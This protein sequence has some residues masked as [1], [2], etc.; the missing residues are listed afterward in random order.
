MYTAIIILNYNNAN[1]TINCVES[2]MKFNTAN[3]KLIVVDNGSSKG[4]TVLVL[5]EYFSKKFI[6]NYLRVQDE[7]IST[8]SLPLLTFDVSGE[9]SGYARGNNKGLSL[10]YRDSEI[11]YIMILNNDTLF[12]DD[13]IPKLLSYLCRLD[14]CAVVTPVLYKKDGKTMD[15]SFARNVHTVNQLILKYITLG[16]RIPGLY[17]KILGPASDILIKH[18]DL[19][20][21]DFFEVN[22]ISGSCFLIDKTT[23]QS[24][25]GFDPNTFLYYEEYI[26]SKKI[27]R[28]AKKNYVIPSAKLI[29]LGGST[30][31]HYSQ[32]TTKANLESA[33]YFLTNYANPNA[34]QKILFRVAYWMMRT[35]I[36]ILGIWNK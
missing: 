35:K 28:I 8:V 23:M 5:H 26:L 34:I 16:F 4:D 15:K 13:I 22:C 19:L 10:A 27:E 31:K 21:N 36:A 25:G 9:N 18:P 32:F 1:D 29:H 7:Q 11:G 30:A 12:V 14:N 2:I 20:K 17:S 6:G 33:N 3:V 24:I